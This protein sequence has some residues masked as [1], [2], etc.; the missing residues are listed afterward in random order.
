MLQKLFGYF[1]D[2]TTKAYVFVDHMYDVY[3]TIV[4]NIFMLCKVNSFI[5]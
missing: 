4:Q 3:V 2:I 5:I 1:K